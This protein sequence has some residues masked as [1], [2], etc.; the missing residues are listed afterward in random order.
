MG[1]AAIIVASGSS[2]RMGFDKLAATVRGTP[3]LAHAVRAF[4]AAQ[5]LTRV[6]VVC[7]EERFRLLHDLAGAKPLDRIDGGAQRQDSVANG[8]SLLGPDDQPA[9]HLNADL[10]AKMRPQMEKYYFDPK[11]YRSY[12]EQLGIDYEK[13]GLKN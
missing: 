12:L 1:C 2:R 13:A 7:P 5:D 6:I 4:M 9:I 10:M 3:V 8:M 11:K